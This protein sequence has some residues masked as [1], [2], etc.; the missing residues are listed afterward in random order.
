MLRA[1]GG[2]LD[3]ACG[4]SRLA[5]DWQA[6]WALAG[7]RGAFCGKSGSLVTGLMIGSGMP[8]MPWLRTHRAH[9]RNTVMACSVPLAGGPADGGPPASWRPEPLELHADA[10]PARQ[11][12][13]RI[14]AIIRRIWA[15]LVSG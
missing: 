3:C 4:G 2:W 1:V 13:I 6:C 11:V 15:S 14:N 10:A 12:L 5:M 7:T 8:G 9:C